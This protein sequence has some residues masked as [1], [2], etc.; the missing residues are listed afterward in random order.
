[1][2]RLQRSQARMAGQRRGGIGG[3]GRDDEIYDDVLDL[4]GCY[5]I[6][7]CVRDPV[8]VR[9]L[10]ARKE[11]ERRRKERMGTVLLLEFSGLW[12]SETGVG[13][14]VS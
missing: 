6:Y 12:V 10:K 8:R 14:G 3:A 5:F 2:P 7:V 1:M 9:E 13:G 11:A 4:D